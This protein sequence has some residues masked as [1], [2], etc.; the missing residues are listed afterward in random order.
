MASQRE[1]ARA[2]K[3]VEERTAREKGRQAAACVSRRRTPATQTRGN[4]IIPSSRFFTAGGPSPATRWWLR[5]RPGHSGGNERWWG[6]IVPP[7]PCRRHLTGP[8]SVCACAVAVV[9]LAT[10]LVTVLC[11]V[12][13]ALLA[14]TTTLL[15]RCDHTTAQTPLRINHHQS[16]RRGT[17]A[18]HQAFALCHC[19][20][21]L[22]AWVHH[23]TYPPVRSCP[24]ITSPPVSSR[25]FPPRKSDEKTG[26]WRRHNQEKTAAAEKR[27]SSREK[28][29]KKKKRESITTGSSSTLT[30]P[31]VLLHHTLLVQHTLTHRFLPPS[32]CRRRCGAASRLCPIP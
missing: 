9:S 14:H 24:I 22:V 6:G 20:V 32:S 27:G 12:L 4:H 1:S 13:V 7:P 17:S 29:K 3:S 21:L 5:A 25:F 19:V 18:S 15:C 16:R 31:R 10:T 30:T 8:L 11:F 23:D 2:E 26:W 28:K